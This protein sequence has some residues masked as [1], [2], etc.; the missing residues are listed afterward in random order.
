MGFSAKALETFATHADR[1]VTIIAESR[2]ITP[3]DESR[4][5]TIIKGES[6]TVTIESESR[7]VS[8]IG[9]TALGGTF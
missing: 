9:K 8:A 4:T 5:V 1:T 7:T 3:I 2:T 6:R